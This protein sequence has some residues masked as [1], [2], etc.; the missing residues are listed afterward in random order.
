MKLNTQ[1]FEL[2]E[3]FLNDWSDDIRS[4]YSGRGMYGSTC[5]GI[6]LPSVSDLF[7]IGYYFYEFCQDNDLDCNIEDFKMSMDNMGLNQIIYFPNIKVELEEIE[8]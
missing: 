5:L 1:Q 7:I 6:V 4:D 8:D 3:S 2:I